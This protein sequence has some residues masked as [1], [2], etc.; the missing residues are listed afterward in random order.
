MDRHDVEDEADHRIDGCGTKLETHL[1]VR[2]GNSLQLSL[3]HPRKE[4][5][6]GNVAHQQNAAEDGEAN[7]LHAMIEQTDGQEAQHQNDEEQ[8]AQRPGSATLHL[9]E[10]FLVCRE[11]EVAERRDNLTTGNELTDG[12]EK[13][14][15][16]EDCY[17]GEIHRLNALNHSR[18]EQRFLSFLRWVAEIKLVVDEFLRGNQ[19]G[20]WQTLVEA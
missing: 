7:L 20:L 2:S 17:D 11:G 13:R 1:C 10:R 5:I 3:E 15:R 19:R 16:A 12:G 6:D 8:S 4:G 9:A 18:L 14:H